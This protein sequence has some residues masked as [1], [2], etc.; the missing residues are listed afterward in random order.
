MRAVVV[1]KQPTYLFVQPM[2]NADQAAR[3]MVHQEVLNVHLSDVLVGDVLDVELDPEDE[4]GSRASRA[5][6]VER[7]ELPRVVGRVV[8]MK[9]ERGFCFVELA[10]GR[11]VFVHT[12]HFHDYVARMSR[13]FECLQVG[14]EVSLE[15]EE[16]GSRGPQGVRAMRIS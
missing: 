7:D 16:T 4:R 3:T 13:D 11:R 8:S 14:S 15:I 9:L 12:K 10:D 2:G 5:D 1:T 6:W